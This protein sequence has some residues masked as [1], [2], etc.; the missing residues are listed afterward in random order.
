MKNVEFNPVAVT[1]ANRET[2]LEITAVSKTTD[3][4]VT[5]N[6]LMSKKEFK[7]STG[8]KGNELTNAFNAMI[9]AGGSNAAGEL[10]KRV[11]KGELIP[12]SERDS[13]NAVQVRFVKSATLVDKAGT[14]SQKKIDA[15]SAE[16]AA[17]LLAA[18]QAKLALP[19][20]K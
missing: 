11:A 16:D 13:K 6:R 7:E 20:A 19:P 15:M 18:L 4:G 3:K 1:I 2:P 17:E 12:T 9:R 8:L 5:T 10:F 14:M